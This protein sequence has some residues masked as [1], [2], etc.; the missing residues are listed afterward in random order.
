[1]FHFFIPSFSLLS[2]SQ[3][4]SLP[5]LKNG[6]FSSASSTLS[7]LPPIYSRCCS[8]HQFSFRATSRCCENHLLSSFS[9]SNSKSDLGIILRIWFM[10][11]FRFWESVILDFSILVVVFLSQIWFVKFSLETL[12]VQMGMKRLLG[13]LS[14]ICGYGLKICVWL[15]ELVVVL[16]DCWRGGVGCAGFEG[17]LA[18]A[19]GV[20]VNLEV[21]KKY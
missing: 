8:K 15:S 4:T 16:K 14:L 11:I 18:L 19:W 5:F 20:Q 1:M 2:V 7:P 13:F 10:D 21:W 3:K 6:S 17:L 12:A 9:S